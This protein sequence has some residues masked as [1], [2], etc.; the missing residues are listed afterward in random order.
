MIAQDQPPAATPPA[1]L[2]WRSGATTLDRLF[3]QPGF[4]DF[5]Q[6][7]RVLLVK[8]LSVAKVTGKFSAPMH[9]Q[10]RMGF[11]FPGADID[12]VIQTRE[13]EI[14]QVVV[15]FLGLA[16]EHGPLP[17]AYCE[18]L[19]RGRGGALREFLDIF[20]HRLILILYRIHA[21]HHPALTILPV[22]DGLVANELF[23]FFGLGHDTDSA[24]RD[25]MALPDRALLDY[26]G[27]LSH[28]PHSASG[29]ERLLEGYF[30]IP[31][32]VEQFTGA[33]VPLD[34]SQ[35]TRI[36]ADAGCNH[37]IGE[38]VV[39]T[40]VWDEHIGVSISLGPLSLEAF[41][42]FLPG[43]N[44]Y[45]P[46]RDLAHFYLGNEFEFTVKLVLRGDQIP[47]AR[48]G[49]NTNSQSEQPALELGWLSWLTVPRDG[50]FSGAGKHAPTPMPAN[51]GDE[52]K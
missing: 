32:H 6:A 39:G 7:V 38:A 5:Y 43:G 4:F 2:G 31:V 52:R 23:A 12:C 42:G 21:M 33:W 36:G 46:L 13:D 51:T 22:S 50:D 44:Q 3:A 25:R 9:F 15:N 20:N 8:Q 48:L 29:L 18:P 34:S 28:R 40:R 37:K 10:S 1:A 19:L 24:T 17:A 35:W 11:D 47:P 16:G 49:G 45:K 41:T 14:P 30:Q 26:S 27:L